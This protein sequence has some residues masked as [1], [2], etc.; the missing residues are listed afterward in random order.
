[1]CFSH[2]HWLIP[3]HY[4]AIV[5]GLWF[6]TLFCYERHIDENDTTVA[7]YAAERF[8]NINVTVKKLEC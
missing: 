6:G 3:G 2:F 5:P 7:I 1:M 4:L 8:A